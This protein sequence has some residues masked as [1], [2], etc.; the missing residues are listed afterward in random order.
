M[1][2]SGIIMLRD[3]AI[4]IYDDSSGGYGYDDGDLTDDDPEEIG[5]KYGEIVLEYTD[6]NGN[7]KLDTV[8]V[9]NLYNAQ[10]GDTIEIEDTLNYGMIACY[11]IT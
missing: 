1:S 3:I 6:V 5:T 7:K 10:P 2:S 4:S 11:S 9:I 8:E